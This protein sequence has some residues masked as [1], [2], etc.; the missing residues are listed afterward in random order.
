LVRKAYVL[1][2]IPFLVALVIC[3]PSLVGSVRPV[4][5][6]D[7]PDLTVDS[8]WLEEASNPGQPVTQV[9]PG[10]QFLI[11][12]SL[13]NLGTATASGYYLDV[14]YDSD[15]GRGG[16][17]NIAPGEAQVWYIGPL[18]AQAG[19]HTTKWIVDPDNQIVE[20]NEGNNE[21]DLTFTIGQVSVTVAANPSGSI[22]VDGAT[23]T[24]SQM[25]TWLPGSSH[26]LSAN[27]PVSNGSG[28]QYV[29]ASWSDGGDQSHTITAP[30]ST[31]TYT[32]NYQAQFQVTYSQ[33]GCSLPVSLPPAEWVNSGGS[34]VGSFPTTVN[35]ED[36]KTQCL[37]Q[38]STPA[39]PVSAPTERAATYKTQYYL[40]VVSS[41]GDSTG[42]GWYDAGSTAT[43]TVTSPVS[44]GAGSQRLFTG[45]SSSDA[46]GYAGEDTSHSVTMNSS[47][48]E[49]ASWKTQWQVTFIVNPSASGEITVSDQPAT[50]AWYD[51]GTPASIRADSKTGYTFSSWSSDAT[52]I[53][54]T[55]SSASTTVTI[56]STGTI[57]ANFLLAD[58]TAPVITPTVTPTA[59]S[60]GWNNGPVTVTWSV[61]DPESG[62]ASSD[63]CATTTLSNETP[64]EGTTLT[65]TVTNN[66]GLS[67]SASVT[68]KIDLTAPTLT[69]PSSFPSVEA[70][71][72][73]GAVVSYDSS[74][75]DSLSGLD[76]LS[77]TPTSGS[78]F[79]PGTTTVSCSVSDK[80]GN[81]AAGTFTVTVQDKT[82]PVVTVPAD[83]TVEATGASG[84]VVTFSVSASDA[85]DGAITP[86]CSP[87]SGSTFVLGSTQVA[88]SVTDKAGNAASGSFTVI[89]VD[90]TP[91][92]LTLPS[93]MTVP[94]TGSS[95]AVVTFTASASDLVDGTVSVT[96][97]PSSGS[98][99]PAGTTSVSCSATDK[100]GN[101][102]SGSFR[103][104]VPAVTVK[105]LDSKGNGLTGGVVQYYSGGWK[106]FGTT[107]S[108]GTVSMALS[109]GTYIFRISYAG[110][111]QEKSQ[112]VASD[113][114]VVFQTVQVHSDSGKCTS[115]IQ[116]AKVPT[117]YTGAGWQTFSQDMEL[118]P[119][120]YMFR[121]SDGT[122][123]TSYTLVVGAVMHIH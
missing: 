113:P 9:N 16:P 121:F 65:C 35:S 120:T 17:D 81:T 103:V 61:S 34:A 5:A 74:A 106:S 4:Q 51:D 60:N 92:E 69:L 43:F 93:D 27:S 41:Y 76:V 111:S 55:D 89:V 122:A 38:S 101:S 104:T 58:T 26:T 7:S 82:V 91:P 40:T 112:D 119:G 20:L 79:P 13:K 50:T 63:G 6:A 108:D 22:V 97:T 46:G 78:T 39:G 67:N 96:C 21:M 8:V 73:N 71:G 54:F 66:A 3:L 23:Y 80:A 42:Q 105:L 95:G 49:T 94:A 99:F 11:V 44:D 15:Y 53:V 45:W 75:T 115:Y 33:T 29:W 64:L 87:A 72:P 37:L 107:G 52:S 86:S 56:H 109:P 32:A 68:V 1:Y 123:N 117:R 12:A 36:G 47:I 31:I 28:T 114:N 118:L 59:N 24:S 77:C 30:N 110:G 57:T 62:I 88:C 18:T 90:R 83:M 10:D 48:T 116:V 98:A 100:A 102:K 14:Y 19:T 70:V 85:V 84:A 2:L 25:F